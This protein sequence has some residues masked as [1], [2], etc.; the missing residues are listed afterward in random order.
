MKNLVWTSKCTHF[1][2]PSG[3]VRGPYVVGATGTAVFSIL[4]FYLIIKNIFMEKIRKIFADY[5]LLCQVLGWFVGSLWVVWLVWIVCCWFRWFVGKL[6]SLCVV[7]S[8]TTKKEKVL[9]L[10]HSNLVVTRETEYVV[11]SVSIW[12]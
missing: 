6:V 2:S 5:W 8:V 4:N 12:S 11:I 1:S 7:S 9:L 3:W 10:R